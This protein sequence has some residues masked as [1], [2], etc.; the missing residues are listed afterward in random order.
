MIDIVGIL[1]VI[2]TVGAAVWIMARTRRS[3]RPKHTKDDDQ[4]RLER[5]VWAWARVLAS[6]PGTAGLG[7]MARVTMELEVHL[8]GSEPYQVKTT[9]LVEQES[10]AFVEVGKEVPLKVDPLGPGHI[11]PNGPWAKFV[12]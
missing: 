2:V 1:V 7:G 12:E 6:M 11:Y 4:T 8:P 10:L 5:A 9:W 3:S